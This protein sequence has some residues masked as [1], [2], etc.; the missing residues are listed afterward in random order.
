MRTKLTTAKKLTLKTSIMYTPS[1]PG[2]LTQKHKDPQ[3]NPLDQTVTKDHGGTT[4]A[5]QTPQL[6]Y[7]RTPR[8]I[9]KIRT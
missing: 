1:Q 7:K 3:T 2:H 9:Q 4:P 5:Q 6:P 8:R